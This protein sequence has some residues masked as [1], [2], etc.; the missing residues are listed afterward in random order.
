M[1]VR[2]TRAPTGTPLRKQEP[3]RTLNERSVSGLIEIQQSGHARRVR[4]SARIMRTPTATAPNS[5]VLPEMDRHNPEVQIM[6]RSGSLRAVRIGRRVRVLNCDF[7]RLVSGGA[8]NEA[9]TGGRRVLGGHRDSRRP[10]GAV[11][12]G[13]RDSPARSAVRRIG[14]SGED[15]HHTGRS[16]TGVGRRLTGEAVLDVPERERPVRR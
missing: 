5:T 14:R 12:G 15:H 3:P 4:E 16:S 2:S 7:E 9:F 6:D 10:G 13:R 11:A 1:V 8:T